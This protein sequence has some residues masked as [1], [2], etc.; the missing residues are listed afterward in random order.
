MLFLFQP[1]HVLILKLKQY[2]SIKIMIPILAQDECSHLSR[3]LELSIG[4]TV[5]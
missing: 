5:V 3:Y 1:I 2:N 4:Y